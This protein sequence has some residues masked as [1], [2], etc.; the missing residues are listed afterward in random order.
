MMEVNGVSYY[1]R[2]CGDGPKKVLLLHGFTGIGENFHDAISMFEDYGN[3]TFIFL[4]FL[5]H[6]K[7]SIPSSSIRYSM[8]HTI[9]DVKTILDKLMIKKLSIIG[10]SMG[11]RVGLSFAAAYP[12]YMEKLVLESASPGIKLTNEQQERVKADTLL[13]ERIRHE[14]VQAFVDYWSAIP[15]FETQRY[16]PKEKQ[17]MIYEQRMKNS[18][19]GLVNSLLG[20]GTGAQPS[21]W[22]RLKTLEAKTLL[23]AGELDEKFVQIAQE[24]TK[25]MKNAEFVKISGAGHAIHVEQPRKFGKIVSEFLSN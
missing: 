19:I 16:L 7:S 12:E 21:N 13:A 5:G 14:G 9:R 22:D 15:L 11:G 20:L 6:G 17:Q 3:F 1:V 23:L 18:P 2:T 8:E 10:Y 24:M 4:D 25:H